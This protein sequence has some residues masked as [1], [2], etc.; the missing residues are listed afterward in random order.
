LSVTFAGRWFSPGNPDSPTNKTDR[1]DKTEILLKVALNTI[2]QPINVILNWN[3]PL[4][5]RTQNSGSIFN[6][7]WTEQN[8]GTLQIRYPLWSSVE[9][10]VVLPD[11]PLPPPPTSPNHHFGHWIILHFQ[12]SLCCMFYY[13]Y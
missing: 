12:S 7:H 8:R 9:I 5:K 1:H 10:T 4:V 6:T 3:W 2:N 11:H 13:L